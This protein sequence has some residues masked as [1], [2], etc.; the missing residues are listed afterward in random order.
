MPRM[1]DRCTYEH[2]KEDACRKMWAE[3]VL[4]ALQDY[5]KDVMS[6][7]RGE[8][9][10]PSGH[11]AYDCKDESIRS[12]KMRAFREFNNPWMQEVVQMAGISA[13]PRMMAEIA[14]CIGAMN[15]SKMTVGDI[16]EYRKEEGL[17]EHR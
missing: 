1:A 12:V 15:R 9:Y 13:T 14:V 6:I 7:N 3:V 10:M 4:S 11:K 8:K 16:Y 17:L 5:W 2:I